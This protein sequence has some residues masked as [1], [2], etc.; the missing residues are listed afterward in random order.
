M[1]AKHLFGPVASRRLGVSLGVDL[2]TSK[3][4]SHDCPYCEAGWTTHLTLERGNYV[5]V[6]E[7]KRELAEL[8]GTRPHIDCITFSGAGEPT[9]NI[10]IGEV[11]NFVK[12]VFP[13]YRLCLLT[14]GSLLGD[15]AVR[16]DIARV[17]LVVPNLD[18]SNESEFAII[19][20]PAPGLNFSTFVE[21]LVGFTNAFEGEI[22]LEMFIAPGVND[23]DASIERFAEI[24]KRM[25]VD[26]IQLNTLDRPG[27]DTTIQAAPPAT[28]KRFV[29]VLEPLAP[30]E[31]VG[32][33]R[34]KSVALR[35]P[36]P[37]GELASRIIALAS[38]RQVTRED[39]LVAL[40][41]TPD[42]LESK[43]AELLYCGALES[44]RGGR[45]EFFSTSQ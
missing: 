19:N 24:V 15:E 11:V 43:L 27:C 10:G 13:E 5:D 22:F 40:N 37:D 30:V 41:V 12:D 33:F 14:N 7:V 18:A 8:L 20:R 17:D 25:R 28:V 44:E 4:C 45:G 1:N 3:I 16:R 32:S 42:V 21:G 23:S 9:L 35:K 31:A 36:L 34:Y 6:E 29:R 39:L 2:V 38:R 26:K